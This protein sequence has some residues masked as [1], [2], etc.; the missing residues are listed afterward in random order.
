MSQSILVIGIGN[1][2]RSD[3]AAGLLACRLLKAKELQDTLIIESNGDGVA[4]MEAWET[5]RRVFLIDTVS[6][7]AKAGTIHR[8]DVL[9][10]PI[11]TQLSLQSSHA[12]GV[13][14][15]IGL[16]RALHQLPAHLIIYGI[17][18]KNFTAGTSLSQEVESSVQE[19]VGQMMH[20][21]EV[22]CRNG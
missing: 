13:A 20:E 7:G 15:A 8:F 22:A 6:S 11:P 9:T 12:F 14:E 17:E 3:D 1:E 5:P 10:Q 16:A 21:V 4:L 18:G 19:V 2:Y